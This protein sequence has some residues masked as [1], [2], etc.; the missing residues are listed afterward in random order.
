MTT[1]HVISVRDLPAA[2]PSRCVMHHACRLYPSQLLEYFASTPGLRLKVVGL[3]MPETSA[4]SGW[5]ASVSKGLRAIRNQ[6]VVVDW[7]QLHAH[8]GKSFRFL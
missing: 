7:P 5:A 4:A 2:L 1:G 8:F 6:S 3:E